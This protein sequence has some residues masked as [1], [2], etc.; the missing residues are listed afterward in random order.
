MLIWAIGMLLDAIIPDK[1]KVPKY[2]PPK[3]TLRRTERPVRG[4]TQR[5]TYPRT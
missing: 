2:E 4:K 3:E 1:Y 5:K